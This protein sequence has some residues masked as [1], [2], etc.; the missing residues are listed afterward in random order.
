MI[1]I[2]MG[3]E[4]MMMTSLSKESLAAHTNPGRVGPIEAL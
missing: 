1:Y 4:T 2:N 3:F